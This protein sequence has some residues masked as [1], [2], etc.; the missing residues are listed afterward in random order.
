MD[1]NGAGATATAALLELD[2]DGVP[3]DQL[4]EWLETMAVIREFEES[5]E[6][7]TASGKIPGSVHQASGQEAVAVGVMRALAPT[8]IV[9]SPHRPHHHA[10][11]KGMTA[12]VVMAEL[13]G[14]VGGWRAAVAGR[15][16]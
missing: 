13:W 9:A 1:E 7:L 11:A 15:C 8:D 12:D 3:I 4:G 10:I 14:R 2:F 16:T 5:L 6:A